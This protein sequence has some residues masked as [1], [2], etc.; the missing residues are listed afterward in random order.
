[1]IP[2]TLKMHAT[3]LTRSPS[4]SLWMPSFISL[5]WV[6][7]AKSKQSNYVCHGQLRQAIPQPQTMPTAG[8]NFPTVVEIHHTC[9]LK[10]LLDDLLQ[11]MGPVNADN[12]SASITT[13]SG[14]PKCKLPPPLPTKLPFA[15][16]PANREKL[17]QFLV[18]HYRDS[19]FN[20]CQHQ[21][22]PMMSGPQN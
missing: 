8:Y 11:P 17:Q 12:G 22:L 3:K 4:A 20:T 16:T 10:E 7:Q 6:S 9:N 13:S 5:V 18:T 2:I 14:C 19:T 1:M 15:P 21:P